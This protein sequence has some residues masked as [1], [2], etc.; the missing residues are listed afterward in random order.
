MNHLTHAGQKCTLLVLQCLSF[1]AREEKKNPPS[2]IGLMLHAGLRQG[3]S[4]GEK[5]ETGEAVARR[6]SRALSCKFPR[7]WEF[8]GRNKTIPLCFF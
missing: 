2:I 1:A 5:M 8:V 6:G 4:Y 3:H 7:L